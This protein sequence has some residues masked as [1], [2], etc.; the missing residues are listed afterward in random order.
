MIYIFQTD[1]QKLSDVNQENCNL[2][3]WEELAASLGSRQIMKHKDK[4]VRLYAACCLADIMRIFAP[5][6]PYD[7][8]QQSVGQMPIIMFVLPIYVRISTRLSY[9]WCI[10]SLAI[11]LHRISQ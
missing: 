4:D 10:F 9:K 5:N 7:T 2:Q 11:F 1:F 8:A 6:A 3:E